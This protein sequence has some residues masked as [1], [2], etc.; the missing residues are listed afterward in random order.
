MLGQSGKRDKLHNRSYVLE[1]WLRFLSRF[2]PSEGG[3]RTGMGGSALNSPAAQFFQVHWP[4]VLS[5]DIEAIIAHWTVE[6]QS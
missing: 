6:N 1:K 4:L 5:Q 3:S 2:T